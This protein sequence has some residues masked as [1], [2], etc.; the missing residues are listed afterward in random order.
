MAFKIRER[1]CKLMTEQLD[2]K[3]QKETIDF[4]RPSKKAEGIRQN[5]MGSI[6]QAKVANG[7]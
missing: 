5:A 7:N 1:N 2:N 4:V 3:V 6:D